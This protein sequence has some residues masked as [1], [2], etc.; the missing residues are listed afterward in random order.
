MMPVWM[1]G[2]FKRLFYTWSGRSANQPSPTATSL[3]F[4]PSPFFTPAFPLT[5]PAPSTSRYSDNDGNNK[6]NDDKCRR[7]Q[8]ASQWKYISGLNITRSSGNVSLWR[9]VPLAAHG[10]KAAAGDV[11]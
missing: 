2:N 6:S 3:S 9:C 1:L 5:T 10:H 4:L 7:V 11:V 8:V